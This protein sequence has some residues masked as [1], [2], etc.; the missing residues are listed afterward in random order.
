MLQVLKFGGTSVANATNISRVL[1]IVD[2]ARAKSRV[3][4][5]CSAI[6]GCTD[7]LLDLSLFEKGSEEWSSTFE[8]LQKRHF[9]IIDRLFTGAEKENARGECERLFASLAAAPADEMVTFGEIFS[10]KIIARKLA[11]DGVKT[12]WL[13]SRIL[14]IKG[15]KELTVNNISTAVALEPEVEVFVAPGFIASE[16]DGKVTTLG[17]GGS[18]FSAAIYAAALKADKLEIWTD[19]PGIMTAN[20]KVVPTALTIPEMSYQ[21]ALDMAEHGA[22]VLYAPTVQ[23]AMD[24]GIAI[25]I[26][27]TFDPEHPGTVVSAL[28]AKEVASWVGV[29]ST[30]DKAR[31]ESLICL[32]SDGP[33]NGQA[34]CRRVED[35]LKKVGISSL[36]TSSDGTNVYS[37]VRLSVAPAA[38]NAIHREY[39]ESVPL[40]TIDLYI[41]GYGNVGK[42]LIELIG[43]SARTVAER[44]GKTLR[45]AGVSNSKRYIIDNQGIAPD[46]VE[47]LLQSGESAY[48]GAFYDEVKKVA[49]RKSVFVDCTDDENI[50]KEFEGLLREGLNIVSSNRRSFAV[51]Y[52]EYA[53]MN[54]AAQ[55]NGVFLR[56]ETTVGSALPVLDS[57]SRS[58]NTCDEII[59][60]E[61][62][63]SCTLNKILSDYDN[64]PGSFAELLQ[65]AQKEGLTEADPRIDLAGGDAL[66]KLLIMARQAGVPLEEA[67]VTVKPI[68]SWDILKLPLEDFYRKLLEIEPQFAASE[69]YAD[70]KH[71]HQRFVASLVKDPESRLGYKA[72]IQVRL[73]DEKHPAYWLTGTENAIIIRSAFHPYPLVIEGA[74]EGAKQAA[75]SVLND[76]LR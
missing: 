6:S 55:E 65:K 14:V 8:I 26:R 33:I 70:E 64:V 4:L 49:P 24:S 18:D 9:A 68:V 10:T 3:V 61:A 41:A 22:K 50:Y 46:S 2:T 71:C 72:G 12:K 52:V 48:N 42:A 63:V 25:N 23:P 21:A 54:V 15:N 40:S 57:I 74:G 16:Y 47:R 43:S 11:C 27:N 36:G 69:D 5:I 38:L 31:G 45:I 37:T 17:R 1:D 7:A 13:D 19:V 39:F 34:A 29:T 35:C 44:T 56:Y 76:I 30:D 66:R 67:D 20:P 60:I 28:P 32:V 53:A 51:P 62:V 59:S 75:S 73:V 58:A